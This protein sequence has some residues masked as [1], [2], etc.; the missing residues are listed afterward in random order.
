MKTWTAWSLCAV[1]AISMAC[2]DNVDNNQEEGTPA[3][4][5]EGTP[6]PEGERTPPSEEDESFIDIQPEYLEFDW[7]GGTKTFQVFSSSNW[8]ASCESF[9]GA[10]DCM[11]TPISGNAHE[12]MTVTVTLSATEEIGSYTS[13]ATVTITPTNGK[14]EKT[15]RV[16]QAHRKHQELYATPEVLHVEL[17]ATEKTIQV[18]SYMDWSASCTSYGNWCTVSPAS[19]RGDGTVTVHVSSN[20]NNESFRSATVEITSV[21]NPA[22]KKTISVVQNG[23]LP[24]IRSFSPSA[25]RVGDTLRIVAENIHP[26]LSQNSVTVNGVEARILSVAWNEMVVEVPRGAG[27]GSVRLVTNGK[28]AVS[29]SQFTFLLESTAIANVAASRMTMGSDDTLYIISGNSI[30]SVETATGNVSTLVAATAFEG[31]L[32]GI[33]IDSSGTLYVLEDNSGTFRILKVATTTGHVATLVEATGFA[34]GITMDSD[35]NLYVLEDNSDNFRILKV[36]TSSGHVATHVD[37]TAFWGSLSSITVAPD[38]NFY[39]ANNSAFEPLL[40]RVRAAG[41]LS[42]VASLGHVY[43]MTM[44]PDGN[45]YVAVASAIYR[46][47]PAGEAVAVFY[48]G[49]ANLDIVA[50]SAGNFYVSANGRILKLSALK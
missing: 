3:L 2:G 39:A 36:D 34:G 17:G 15:V 7:E 47:T 43:G 4:E 40:C 38:G 45:L 24:A 28:P 46:V 30:R 27:S 31:P 13:V 29:A 50:D 42:A 10:G 5:G 37:T 33:A 9:F 1:L 26:V 20:A 12:T 22:L 41:V 49:Y 44:A 16:Y 18:S 35:D 6:P 23:T 8:S 19:G 25:A 21:D 32:A 14:P 48:S 11:V